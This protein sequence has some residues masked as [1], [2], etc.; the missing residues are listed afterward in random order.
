MTAEELHEFLE[1]LQA[2]QIELR[3]SLDNSVAAALPVRPDNAIGRLTRQDALQTQQLALELRRRKRA[4][5]EQVD[6]AIRRM[7]RGVYGICTRCEEEISLARLKVQP[8]A[9]LCVRCAQRR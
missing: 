4:R 7:E 9:E 8:D 5:L 6:R 3:V 2:T 1:L